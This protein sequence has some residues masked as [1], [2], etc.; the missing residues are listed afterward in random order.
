MS[1][2]SEAN[3]IVVGPILSHP[4]ADKLELTMVGGY[5]MV[6]GKGQFKEG[7]LAVFVQPD[8]VV[9]QTDPFKFIWQDHVG[10]DGTVPESRRRVIPRRFR[11]EWSEGLLMPVAELNFTIDTTGKM[12]GLYFNG[13][14]LMVGQDVAE[15]LGI[16]R[17]V[18]EFDRE[19][20]KADTTAS[21]R[22]KYPKTLRGWFYW[23]LRKLGWKNAGGKSYKLEVS[24]DFPVYDINAYKHAR[25]K[26]APGENVQV[27]EKIHGCNARF[28]FVADNPDTVPET[29]IYPG[30]FY[31]GS[32]EQWKK[33]GPNVWW[34]VTRQF[35]EIEQWC[36]AHP[37]KVLYAEVGPCQ[38][39]G[40]VNFRYGAGEN[41]TF[42]FTFDVYN[43]ETREFTWAGNEGMA[44][45]APILYAGPFDEAAILAL[46]DGDS[47]V[48]GA[49]HLREGIV[50]RSLETG[51][52]LKV[53]SNDYLTL[54]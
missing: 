46:V 18:E 38:K 41:E 10:L 54:K 28:V 43:P 4:N 22:R 39:K 40:K 48:P 42:V 37:G 19:N 36:I 12:L 15:L 9:P 49:K 11:K 5:Q 32:H 14:S 17:Y 31:V 20:T 35:P 52:R 26:F 2:T 45:N 8:C 27:T 21:P 13:K 30:T 23:T 24:F 50:I 6:I 16:T 47:V 33:D 25:R 34:N 1:N 51:Q 7:D 29:G 53:V 44:L 3:V